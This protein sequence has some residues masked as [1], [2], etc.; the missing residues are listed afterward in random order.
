MKKKK[1][2]FDKRIVRLMKC[3]G[4]EYLNN[5]MK[6]STVSIDSKF[7]KYLIENFSYGNEKL[8]AILK[9]DD[10][11]NKCAIVSDMS[12]YKDK[13]WGRTIRIKD[14]EKYYKALRDV[15]E[16]INPIDVYNNGEYSQQFIR[17]C[18]RYNLS[19]KCFI[20][21]V[22]NELNKFYSAEDLPI[23]DFF[24]DWMI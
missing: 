12:Y 23:Y 11:L 14:G 18:G 6:E 2:I 7:I 17:N 21:D 19:T 5:Y 10:L 9:S 8:L 16:R 22:Y 4:K 3:Y 15:S 13:L 24:D 1:A 20:C